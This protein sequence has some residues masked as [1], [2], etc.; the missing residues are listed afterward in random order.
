MPNLRVAEG[1]VPLSQFKAKAAELL[2]K[3]SETGA[4]IVITQNG[5]AAGVLL[6]PAEFDLL[7]ERARFVQA[8]SEG[9][10]DVETDR[11][12]DHQSMVAEITSRYDDTDG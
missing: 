9:I 3:I 1:I 7:T 8:I 11:V 5:R 6:S 10:T 12:V 2:K 4:P